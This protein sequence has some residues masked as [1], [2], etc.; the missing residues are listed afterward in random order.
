MD[1]RSGDVKWAK[2]PSALKSQILMNTKGVRVA[3]HGDYL[4][5]YIQRDHARVIE[6]LSRRT[7][8]TV[9]V[10]TVR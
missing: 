2:S 9:S 1:A 6:V 4:Y 7:G 5:V 8:K 10:M 3:P